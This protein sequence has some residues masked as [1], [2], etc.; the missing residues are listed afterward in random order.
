M[1]HFPAGILEWCLSLSWSLHFWVY[2]HF[3]HNHWLFIP[4]H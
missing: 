3:F 1:S 2:S 4:W